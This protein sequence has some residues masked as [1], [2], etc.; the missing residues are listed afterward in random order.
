MR[1]PAK[2]NGRQNVATKIHVSNLSSSTAEN[3]LRTLFEGDSR[4]V[5]RVAIAT[6]RET[7]ERRGFALVQMTT[8]ED[9]KAA[10]DALNG[11]EVDGNALAVR[12][13]RIKPASP[14]AS[15]VDARR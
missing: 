14:A 9:A 7:G 8:P 11:R 4:T 5:E 12:L 2:T 3:A 13:A 1:Q 10:I 6:D 15:I